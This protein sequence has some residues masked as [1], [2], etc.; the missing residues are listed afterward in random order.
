MEGAKS[1]RELKDLSGSWFHQNDEGLA[2]R[3]SSN[4]QCELPTQPVESEG[5]RSSCEGGE[6][7]LREAKT[8]RT[9]GRV[10]QAIKA[11]VE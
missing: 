11:A 5:D 2:I 3:A 1:E 4:V 6:G 10:M 7:V 8:H 9:G